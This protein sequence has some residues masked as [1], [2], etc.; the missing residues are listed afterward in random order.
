MCNDFEISLVVFMTNITT[1]HTIT[2]TNLLEYSALHQ[3]PLF[4]L[5]SKFDGKTEKV[6]Y[7]A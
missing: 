5:L 4:Q 1:N 7:H 3:V 2:D 6:C